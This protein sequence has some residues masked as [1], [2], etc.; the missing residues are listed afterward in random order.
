MFVFFIVDLC[1]EF[2]FNL[3]NIVVSFG[4]LFS[5]LFVK[6]KWFEFLFVSYFLDKLIY[7]WNYV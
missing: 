1:F 7:V 6:C 3:Y 5:I 4:F 2:N